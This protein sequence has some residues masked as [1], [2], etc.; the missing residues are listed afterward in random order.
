[1]RAP[2]EIRHGQPQ[3]AREIVSLIESALQASHRVQR[4]RDDAVRAAQDIASLCRREPP[5]GTSQASSSFVLEGMNH[6]A[7][8]TLILAGCPRH[9]DGRRP[10]AASGTPLERLADDA[11]GW[12]GI[13]AGAA[14]GRGEAANAAPAGLADRAA[15]RRIEDRRAC[16]ALRRQRDGEQRLCGA[17]DAASDEAYD[18]ASDG[19]SETSCR[20]AFPQSRSRE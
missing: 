20:S 6:V 3:C 12:K 16:R 19:A 7:Q 8:G 2:Q 13:A 5:Q 18:G 17:Y 11:P 15:G 10:A 14:E 4:D 1:M 9:G